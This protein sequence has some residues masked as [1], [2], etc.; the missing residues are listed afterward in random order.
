MMSETSEDRC[1]TCGHERRHHIHNSG[2]CRPGFVC[3]ENCKHFTAAVPGLLEDGESA[4]GPW[5]VIGGPE[6]LAALRRVAAGDSPDIVYLELQANS[7][8]ED[9][10]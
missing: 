4:V 2:S 8:N 6:L 7:A 10:R 9:Y 1:Q 3:A 5:W